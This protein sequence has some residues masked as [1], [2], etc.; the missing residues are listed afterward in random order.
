MKI[1]MGTPKPQSNGPLY[2]KTVIS[3]LAVDGRCQ[4]LGVTF[5]VLFSL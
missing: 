4:D 3:T 2:G 1:A 5:T